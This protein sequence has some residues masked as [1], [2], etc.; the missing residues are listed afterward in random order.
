LR[1]D[2]SCF[3][4]QSQM[5]AIVIQVNLVNS[6]NLYICIS[7]P[8]HSKNT[9]THNFS[10]NMFNWCKTLVQTCKGQNIE[11]VCIFVVSADIFCWYLHTISAQN[12]KAHPTFAHVYK[13]WWKVF[14]YTREEKG[15]SKFIVVY[16]RFDK[17]P[18]PS[19]R[20]IGSLRTFEKNKLVSFG[21]FTSHTNMVELMAC[22]MNYKSSQRLT[23]FS[24]IQRCLVKII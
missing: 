19:A 17:S 21:F 12:K 2:Y 23:F 22:E 16:Y 1:I 5:T 9:R 24:N 6:Q 14:V 18:A 15:G 4:S 20:K 13:P 3:S 7:K 8:L 11:K 10:F